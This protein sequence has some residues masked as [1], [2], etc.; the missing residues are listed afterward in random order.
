MFNL[1]I[2]NF[3]NV[4]W[5]WLK[6]LITEEPV[7]GYLVSYEPSNSNDVVSYF[8][9]YEEFPKEVSYEAEIINLGQVTEVDLTLYLHD[10]KKY[11]IGISAVDKIGNESDLQLLTLTL[12]K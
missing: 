11:N 6:E 7:E 9:Y 12:K 8:L 2:K 3:I 5:S 1:R 4:F 10:E